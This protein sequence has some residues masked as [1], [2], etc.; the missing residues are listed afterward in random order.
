LRKWK[1]INILVVAVLVFFVLF[2]TTVFSD[3]EVLAVENEQTDAGVCDSDGDSLDDDMECVFYGT[4]PFDADTDGD[5]LNDDVEIFSGLDPL[6][7][8]SN[9]PCSVS[10][11]DGEDAGVCDSDGDSL[12]D[13]MECVFYGTDPFDAD[14][15]G[16]GLNDDVE[17]FSGSDPLTP[18]ANNP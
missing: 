16:D 14:T 9:K 8:C 2:G 11:V 1:I 7:P 6:I 10:V 18:N 17:I 13:D 4:D 5:G 12:D 15:D 3:Q